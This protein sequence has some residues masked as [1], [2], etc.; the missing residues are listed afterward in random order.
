MCSVFRT[1]Y[2]VWLLLF[3]DEDLIEYPREE[4]KKLRGGVHMN[5]SRASGHGALAVELS[6]Q[7]SHLRTTPDNDRCE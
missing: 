7:S 2:L 6:S 3:G 1:E 5:F 4:E